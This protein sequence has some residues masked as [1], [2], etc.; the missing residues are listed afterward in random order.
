MEL[1]EQ[2]MRGVQQDKEKEKDAPLA[3]KQNCVRNCLALY[4][5][6]FFF[7]YQTDPQIWQAISDPCK[8]L[9]LSV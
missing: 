5:F 9:C 3:I 7:N 8:W 4:L 1:E 2:Q 6:L